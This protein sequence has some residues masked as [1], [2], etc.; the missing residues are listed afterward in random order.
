MKLARLLTAVTAVVAAVATSNCSA[1]R[2]RQPGPTKLACGARICCSIV[3]EGVR[4]YQVTSPSRMAL[5]LPATVRAVS[6][7]VPS[8]R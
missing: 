8:L 1:F 7:L 5:P 4:R 3:P 2:R 6:I